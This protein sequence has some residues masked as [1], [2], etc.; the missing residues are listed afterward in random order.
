MYDHNPATI[1]DLLSKKLSETI[2]CLTNAENLLSNGISAFVA[3]VLGWLIGASDE[4]IE[5][6]LDI[7]PGS[8]RY[9]LLTGIAAIERRDAAVALVVTAEAVS[10]MRKKLREMLEAHTRFFA[11]ESHCV[12]S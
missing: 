9:N 2:V 12:V 6:E 3:E 7:V 5:T 11:D 8:I 1:P 10:S 4:L